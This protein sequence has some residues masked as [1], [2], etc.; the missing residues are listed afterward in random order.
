[1]GKLEF[2]VAA[3]EEE[4]AKFLEK[5][6]SLKIRWLTKKGQKHSFNHRHVRDFYFKLIYS[7]YKSEN[8]RPVIAGLFVDGE[9]ICGNLGV[10]HGG[11]FFGLIMSITED[12]RYRR[13]S[14]G[15]V[16]LLRLIEYCYKNQVHVI[17]LGRGGAEFKNKYNTR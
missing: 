6:I 2:R 15:K 12:L 1:M 8:L 4:Q 9:Q 7:P 13:Y 16:L 5:L 10:I 17:D 14:P 3:G 11:V